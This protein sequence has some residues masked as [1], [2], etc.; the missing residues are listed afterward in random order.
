L[1]P[2]S[3]QQKDEIKG[4]EGNHQSDRESHVEQGVDID[5]MRE[6]NMRKGFDNGYLVNVLPRR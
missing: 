6:N 2:A 4:H 1:F 3:V 5:D